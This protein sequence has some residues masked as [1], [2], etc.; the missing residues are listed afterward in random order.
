MEEN[1]DDF[2]VNKEIKKIDLNRVG[3]KAHV[4]REGQFIENIY[5]GVQ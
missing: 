5:Y 4:L 1:L 2:R 3:V